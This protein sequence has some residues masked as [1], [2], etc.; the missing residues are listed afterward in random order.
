MSIIAEK[1]AEILRSPEQVTAG[2]NSGNKRGPQKKPSKERLKTKARYKAA[3]D[4]CNRLESKS[5]LKKEAVKRLAW[6]R[7]EVKNGRGHFVTRNWCNA[8]Q[9]AS[10][11]M[12]RCETGGGGPQQYSIGAQGNCEAT[13]KS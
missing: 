5:N 1:E 13:T 10:E 8:C 12:K 7:E 2:S 3:V 4:I 6:A 11:P 9:N